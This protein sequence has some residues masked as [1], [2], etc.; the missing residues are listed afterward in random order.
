MDKSGNKN[1][2]KKVG[3]H[4]TKK[5]SSAEETVNRVKRQPAELKKMFIRQN[6]MKGYSPK[7]IRNSN[8]LIARN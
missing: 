8:N 5:L 2:N 7:Y 6:P 4:Q 3:L 1:K